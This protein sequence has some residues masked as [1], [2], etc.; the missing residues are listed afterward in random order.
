VC[1]STPEFQQSLALYPGRLLSGGDPLDIFTG[2]H[3]RIGAFRG[4]ATGDFVVRGR[5]D[6]KGLRVAFL[7]ALDGLIFVAPAFPGLPK[8]L[9]TVTERLRVRRRGWA[10]LFCHRDVWACSIAFRTWMVAAV[11]SKGKLGLA[12][13]GAPSS[14]FPA[15]VFRAVLPEISFSLGIARVWPRA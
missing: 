10:V 9:Y 13:F 14:G 11:V 5:L 8:V 6:R 15:D 7:R 4:Y 1:G 2:A 3:P 12:L